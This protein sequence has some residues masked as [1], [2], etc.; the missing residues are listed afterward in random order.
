MRRQIPVVV[1]FAVV[2]LVM[3]FGS[4]A[5][6]ATISYSGSV[7]L[8]ETDWADSVS[9]TQF[10]PALGT[11]NSVQ[12][13]VDA[14]LEGSARFE[15][16]GNKPATITMGVWADFQVQR[17]DASYLVGAS[18]GLFADELVTNFD[19]TLDFG[20]TSGRTYDPFSAD[21]SNAEVTSDAADLALFTGTGDIVLPVRADA[22]SG[23]MGSGNLLLDVQ[24]L[25]SA[26]VTV[27]YDYAPVPEPSALVGLAGMGLVGL[28]MWV[29]RRRS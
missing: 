28:G 6:S 13:N 10:N 25:A 4:T 12:I 16:R 15:H 20:G 7:A 3:A 27:T 8:T 26:G 1:W 23:A 11:L 2:G 9:I 29:R 21:L 19:G 18:P 14:H 17:P 22:T 24:T 5:F